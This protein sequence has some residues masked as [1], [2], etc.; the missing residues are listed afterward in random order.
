VFLPYDLTY[1]QRIRLYHLMDVRRYLKLKML[2]SV[3]FCSRQVG[4]FLSLFAAAIAVA[5][6]NMAQTI[7]GLPTTLIEN[8]LIPLITTFLLC[9]LLASTNTFL[10]VPFI[11]ALFNNHQLLMESGR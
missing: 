8:Q 9:L 2:S 1:A 10:C 4:L 3:K 5:L 7:T 11:E 6:S